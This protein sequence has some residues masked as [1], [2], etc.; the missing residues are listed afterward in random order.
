MKKIIILILLL[1]PLYIYSQIETITP[2][3]KY[4]TSFAIV[5]DKET[6][7]AT[8]DAVFA[9]RDMLLSEGLGAYILVDETGNADNIREKLH[10][11]YRDEPQLE[12]CV[13]IGDIPIPMIRDGQH[14]SSAFKMD[15]S[16]KWDRSSIPSDRFYDDFGLEFKFLKKDESNPLLH[17]YSLETNSSMR[18]N[19]N[20]YSARIKPIVRKDAESPHHQVKAYL[21]KVVAERNSSNKLDNLMMF[22]GHGYNS[23]ALEA[24]SGEQISLREQLPSVFKAGS[25]AKF[26]G[27]ENGFPMKHNLLEELQR[28]DLDVALFH[29]H[30]APDL[31]Y[32]NRYPSVRSPQENI[33][34]IKFYT[35]GK[36]ASGLRRKKQSQVELEDYYMKYLGI[37]REWCLVN[38]STTIM[39]SIMNHN[40][41][42]H[43]EDIYNAKP[44]ARFIMFDAC[45]NG[46]FNNDEYIA[47][48][49]IFNNG[50]TITTL[51]NTVNSLQDKF[52]NELIGLLSEGVRVGLW[53]KHI[54]YLETH[55]IGDPTFK[56]AS[57]ER[58]IDLNTALTLKN[59]DDNFWLSLLNDKK[60]DIQALALRKLYQNKYPQISKLLN[61]TY[62]TSEFGSVRLEAVKLSV[63]LDNDDTIDILAQTISDPYELIRRLGMEYIGQNGDPRLAT[64]VINAMIYDSTS[65]RVMFK[66]SYAIGF[67]EP[68]VMEEALKNVIDNNYNLLKKEEVRERIL[69]SI[70][71][72][73]EFTSSYIENMR[74]TTSKEKSRMVAIRSI[75][76]NTAHHRLSEYMEL[77][78]SKSESAAIRETMLEALS[79]YYSSYRRQEIVDLCDSIIKQESGEVLVK[80]AQKTKNIII[81]K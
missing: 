38:D 67:F 13:L 33:E 71:S 16:L 6:Y 50:N 4:K 52:P 80:Q 49:Y 3:G 46:A 66:A 77:A 62:K 68:L 60:A 64:S 76:N 41:D 29:E 61:Q 21:E 53:A 24:W 72:R 36:I 18:I 2:K 23:E 37:P 27:Y 45:Y 81:N 58:K 70:K 63:L 56:F 43:L 79:W 39:D 14:L 35:R 73:D 25:K 59:K 44:N 12:G 20:I 15:Q 42:I 22:R 7:Q 54:N 78:I 48:A 1:L 34:S 57:E 32:I 10:K 19:S 9:Y 65:K 26:L 75:R 11:M 5:I 40:M 28:E 31:Q 69:T 8:Q 47:G 74:D 55:I 30:G 51:A 17:Y